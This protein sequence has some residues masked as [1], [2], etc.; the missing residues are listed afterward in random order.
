MTVPEGRM[1]QSCFSAH[2]AFYPKG[3]ESIYNGSSSRSRHAGLISISAASSQ[4]AITTVTRNK[5]GRTMTVPILSH[6]VFKSQLTDGLV[7]CVHALV[8][9]LM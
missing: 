4:E 3:S 8:V 1:L 5:Q 6:A 2:M 9:E 7:M